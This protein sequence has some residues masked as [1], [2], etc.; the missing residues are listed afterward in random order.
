DYSVGYG[1]VILLGEHSVVYG[2]HAIATP[3]QISIKARVEDADEG[4]T[5]LIPR[6]GVEQKLHPEAGRPGSFLGLMNLVLGELGLAGRPM[7]IHVQPDVPRA[8]G[9]GSSAA[10][11]VAIVRAVDAQYQ[12][13]LTDEQVC[14]IA[15]ECEKI[16]HGTPS[17]VD[18]TVATYG[19]TIL[20]SRNDRTVSGGTVVNGMVSNG[21][22]SSGAVSSGA[23]SDG[24]VSDG[25]VSDGAVSDDSLDGPTNGSPTMRTLTVPGPLPIVIGLT[26]TES[27]TAKTVAQVRERW[28]QQP[29]LYEGIFDTIDSLALAA[30]EALEA[31]K[32]DQLGELMNIC[33]GQ[34][35]ALQVSSPQI[36]DLV[37]VARRAGAAGA[38]LTGGGGG[39][40]IVALCPDGG[41]QVAAAMRE[42]G[43]EALEVPQ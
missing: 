34:L 41:A 37:Q 22:V 30:V 20:F 19:K 10:L 13:G 17:G 5:L 2:R 1:K 15:Y 27:L 40:A 8:V 21:S 14:R 33:Q 24:A 6:W 23:V 16:A 25:A 39:G 18:N 9:L 42:A 4:L 31:G 32:F 29:A 35:N 12:V 38:K 11:S 36:E 43:Y 7:R 28:Q 3:L 26:G